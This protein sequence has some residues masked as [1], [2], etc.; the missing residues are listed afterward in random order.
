MPEGPTD[1]ELLA[2]HG[3][4][5]SLLADGKGVGHSPSGGFGGD[6]KVIAVLLDLGNGLDV[7]GHLDDVFWQFWLKKTSHLTH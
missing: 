4:D 7:F 3:G 1:L 5:I 2:V 6:N